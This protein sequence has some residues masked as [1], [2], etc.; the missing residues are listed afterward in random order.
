MIY[1]RPVIQ[2][3]TSLDVFFGGLLPRTFPP[4]ADMDWRAKRLKEFIDS[5]PGKVRWNLDDVCR[6]LGLPMSGRQARRLFMASTGVGIREYA[7][8]RRLTSAAKQLEVTNAPVKAIAADAGYQSTCHFARSF[9]E[10]FCLSPL[11]FRRMWRR[12]MCAA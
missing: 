3:S 4:S 8:R 11:E 12:K 6:E 10:L 7:K 2:V 5:Q 9:K 1:G